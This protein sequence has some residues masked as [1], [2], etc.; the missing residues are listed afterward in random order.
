MEFDQRLGVLKK[1]ASRQ[2]KLLDYSTCHETMDQFPS[3]IIPVSPKSLVNSVVTRS[4]PGYTK[5]IIS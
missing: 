2:L 5:E 3:E 4:Q 1:D